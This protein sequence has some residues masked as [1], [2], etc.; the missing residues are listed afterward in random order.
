MGNYTNYVFNNIGSDHHLDFK[1]YMET[2]FEKTLNYSDHKKQ[3]ANMLLIA[4][5]KM[6]IG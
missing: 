3:Y 6:G 4:F 5:N 1:M 2:E